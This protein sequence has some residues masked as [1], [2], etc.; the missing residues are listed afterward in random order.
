MKLLINEQQE[1]YKNAKIWYICREMFE[2][3]YARNKKY[4]EVWDHCH[5]TSEN[6]GTAHSIHNLKYSIPKEITAVFHY[7]SNYDYS[8]IIK[9][10]VEEFEEFLLV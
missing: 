7:G 5:Y 10:L 2:D 1:S 6:R 3:K 9:E 4:D 8:F